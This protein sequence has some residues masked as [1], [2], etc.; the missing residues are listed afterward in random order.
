MRIKLTLLTHYDSI[1]RDCNHDEEVNDLLLR[2]LSISYRQPSY[3]KIQ[4]VE[5]L[6][7]MR[8]QEAN[9]YICH[10]P[11][12]YR[13]PPP[14]PNYQSSPSPY[15]S[16][17]SRGSKIVDETCRLKI[18]EWCYRIVDFFSL[19]R[20]AV[21][22][23]MSYLERFMAI[24]QIDRRTYKL[25]ATTALLLAIKVHQPKKVSLH[26][27][28]KD[29]SRGQFDQD[30]V[31]RMELMMLPSLSW[32]L[33]PPTP[34]NYVLRLI[35]LN[36]FSS[37]CIQEF[38]TESIKALAIFYVELSVYDHFFVTQRQSTVAI[39]AIMNAMESL[40]LLHPQRRISNSILGFI[41]SM[42]GTMGED[43]DS[44]AMVE[45]RSQLHNLY[46][47]S[48]EFAIKRKV[49]RDRRL[50]ESLDVASIHRP[51]SL[52]SSSMEVRRK[53][54]TNGCKSA[55]PKSVSLRSIA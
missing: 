36:P 23:A 34:A 4:M 44:M 32:R 21:H 41:D 3:K 54:S 17:T 53:H 15:P 10:G 18:C 35:E 27:V 22:Y 33:H 52:S 48:D 13:S 51:K 2:P 9:H 37:S 14:L 5:K 46:T 40:G 29:L 55:S 47:R 11:N 39:A 42:F 31:V 50:D 43:C 30:D 28:V 45:C 16:S 8:K 7:A 6:H 1:E 49:E 38:D 26:K 25:A 20:E 12:P 19:D 24:H